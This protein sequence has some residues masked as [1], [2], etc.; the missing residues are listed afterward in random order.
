VAVSPKNVLGPVACHWDMEIPVQ[1]GTVGGGEG[2]G[3]MGVV[4]SRD[5]SISALRSV[6]EEG[7]EGGMREAV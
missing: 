2:G 4:E 5:R 6:M 7:E 1:L 3:R